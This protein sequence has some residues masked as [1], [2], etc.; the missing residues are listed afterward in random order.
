MAMESAVRPRFRK[1]ENKEQEVEI[2]TEI[3]EV[4]HTRQ[5]LK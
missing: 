1:N 2:H 5:R 4:R 3:L